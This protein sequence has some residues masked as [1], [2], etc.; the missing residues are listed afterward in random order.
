MANFADV[1]ATGTITLTSASAAFSGSGVL[2]SDIVA[3]DLLV[4]QGLV[5][6]INTITGAG[7][8]AG[9]LQ[10]PWAGAGG[11]GLSYVILK[12][13]KSRYDPALVQSKARE[14]IAFLDT[15]GIPYIVTPAAPDP[16]VGEDGQLALKIN[17]APWKL[18]LKV[19]GAWVLQGSPAGTTWRG[20]W[21]STT[22][23]GASDEVSDV[24]GSVTQ[25]YISKTTNINKKPSANPSDWDLAASAGP[26]GPQGI[27][28]NTGPQGPPGPT[29]PSGATGSQGI[30]GPTGP[31]GGPGPTG[32][33]GIQGIQGAGINP[34]ATGTFAQRATYDNQPK[35]FKFLQT[36]VAPFR[37][38][39]KAS[40]TTADWAGPTFI[41]GA[42]AVG[43][44]GSV[45]DTVFETFDLGTLT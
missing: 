12:Y 10:T 6:V 9:T 21:N 15:A 20:P 23:Y 27:Q 37:L 35:D 38:W 33:Q 5:G 17:S 29:G 3:G 4:A 8:D 30:Q 42:A 7:F 36:D 34:D 11:A 25:S 41:G 19:S 40:N 24:V 13:G 2:W 18:W 32:P 28:G 43:D 45:T 44:L 39:V 31:A 16:G 22:T 1:Y 14:M 26:T